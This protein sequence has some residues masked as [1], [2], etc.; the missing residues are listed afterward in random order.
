MSF[1]GSPQLFSIHLRIPEDKNHD[2]KRIDRIQLRDL[3]EFSLFRK[4]T[5]FRKN[6]FFFVTKK[7]F[8][9]FV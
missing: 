9:V 8:V 2:H 5:Y 1:H 7:N 4:N 3:G 6:T